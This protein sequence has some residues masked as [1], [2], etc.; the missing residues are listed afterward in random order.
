MPPYYLSTTMDQAL[1][2]ISLGTLPKGTYPLKRTKEGEITFEINFDFVDLVFGNLSFCHLSEDGTNLVATQSI[3]MMLYF[4]VDCETV[5]VERLLERVTTVR[6]SNLDSLSWGDHLMTRLRE[7]ST[8]KFPHQPVQMSL[9]DL[10][11]LVTCDCGHRHDSGKEG[12]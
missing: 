1:E 8:D 10:S 4:T 7:I 11:R 6:Y 12:C 5:L 2:W 3:P 9:V